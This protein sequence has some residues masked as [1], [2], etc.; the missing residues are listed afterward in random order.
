MYQGNNL[1]LLPPP[2]IG[3][4][5]KKR[6]REMVFTQNAPAYHSL[7]SG[8]MLPNN[9][10]PP[11][12]A[13]QPP[14]VR[15]GF[16]AYE[17]EQMLQ[18]RVCLNAAPCNSH[19][20]LLCNQQDNYMPR[21]P[22]NYLQQLNYLHANET[23]MQYTPHNQVQEYSAISQTGNTCSSHLYN[24]SRPY[25]Y[26]HMK[27]NTS[28]NAPFA[29]VTHPH[30]TTP[31]SSESPPKPE[32]RENKSHQLSRGL[33]LITVSPDVIHRWVP[34]L[35]SFNI[36]FEV[37]AL[38]TQIPEPFSM[39][40]EPIQE[41]IAKVFFLKNPHA[42]ESSTPAQLKCI[43]WEVEN[44]LIQMQLDKIYRVIGS[45]DVK[46]QYMKVFDVRA[47]KLDEIAN[48]PV[49]VARSNRL[50]RQLPLTHNEI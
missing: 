46:N 24:T 16:N 5:S 27:E 11:P 48:W 38:C 2:V 44:Q 21:E 29:H 39:N 13:P 17:Q 43:Y 9:F 23:S 40:G 3:A 33:Q 26:T 30:N 35:D 50:I 20:N 19:G 22:L 34:M 42:K 12:A 41:S 10:P 6:V 18:K 7:P 28:P 47:A 36:I 49:L 4:S 1:R 15:L 37:F 31:D 25:A 8:D 14:T 45:F 32:P